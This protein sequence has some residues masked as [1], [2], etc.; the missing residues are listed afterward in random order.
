MGR[1]DEYLRALVT[2]SGIHGSHPHD[3]LLQRLVV[4]IACKDGVIEP[5]EAELL[6]RVFPG[7]KR[8]ELEATVA[9]IASEPLDLTGMLSSFSVV[10]RPLLIDLAAAIARLDEVLVREEMSALLELRRAIYE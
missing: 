4:H 6:G 8:E 2:G 7:H 10:E 5:S 9:S 3:A 1:I